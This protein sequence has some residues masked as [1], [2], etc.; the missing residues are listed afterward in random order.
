VETSYLTLSTGSAL[1]SAYTAQESLGYARD[2][3]EIAPRGD[4]N[5]YVLRDRATQTPDAVPAVT[6]G[7]AAFLLPVRE[8]HSSHLGTQAVLT[9]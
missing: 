5:C 7:W 1:H 3:V 6:V 9:E 8:F 4:T 2:A